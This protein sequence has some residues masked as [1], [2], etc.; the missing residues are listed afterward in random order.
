MKMALSLVD[1]E[2][3][4]PEELGDFCDFLSVLQDHR[5][6]LLLESHFRRK[7]VL[8]RSMGAS[9]CSIP[10]AIKKPP[11][12]LPGEDR[13]SSKFWTSLNGVVTS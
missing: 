4:Y 12:N 11:K 2:F 6:R 10:S 8:E 1:Q 5:N 9:G 7:I 3:I 13:I